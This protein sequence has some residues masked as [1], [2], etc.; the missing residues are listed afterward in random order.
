MQR[1]SHKRKQISNA[2]I[3]KYQ[4]QIS[5]IS[6]YS[7]TVFNTIYV[8]NTISLVNIHYHPLLQTCFFVCGENF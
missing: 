5:N 4:K 7:F 6:E 1:L 3:S 8:F 2:Q